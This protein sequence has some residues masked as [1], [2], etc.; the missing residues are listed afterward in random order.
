M[1]LSAKRMADDAMSKLPPPDRLDRFKARAAQAADGD[2]EGGGEEGESDTETG[3]ESAGNAFASAVQ[4]GDG[5]W[6]AFCDLM[7]RY[8]AR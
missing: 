8:N 7:D 3:D 6:S 5:V 4:S 1:S 2:D